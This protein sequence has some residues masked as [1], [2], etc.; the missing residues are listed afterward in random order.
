[1][2]RGMVF[3]DTDVH[4]TPFFNLTQPAMARH[5]AMF[6]CRTLDGARRKAAAYGFRGA[7]YPWETGISGDEECEKWLKL[8]THQSHITSDV[9]LAIQRYADCTGDTG[10]FEDFAAEVLI[11][12]AR[13]WVSKAVSNP[14]GSCSIPDAGGPDEFHV[15]CNDSAYVCNLAA[16]NLRLAAAAMH[17]LQATAPAK[18][19]ALVKRCGVA[20]D[21]EARFLDLAGRLRTMRRADGLFEQCAGFF[22]LGEPV[23]GAHGGERPFETQC[24]KQADV[25]MMMYLLPDQWSR[26]DLR[27][28][29]A[30]YEP[31]TIHASSLSHAVHGIVAARLGLS[32]V[33]D[34]YIRRSLGMDLNDEMGNADAGAHMAANGMN[35]LSIVEGYGGCRPC[36]DAFVIESPQL[37]KDWTRLI[38]RLKWRGADFEVEITHQA[39]AV[40][41]A[42]QAKPLPLRLGGKPMTLEP[43]GSTRL[44]CSP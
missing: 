40:R 20:G 27:A 28:N 1:M 12:T 4:M 37:P 13:F 24:V 5:L 36:G 6:R 44:A 14:D 9:A 10:F 16:N 3:W 32:D 2:Y 38:F 35:W 25:I 41:N 42:V 30:Y 34:R 17:R 22:G 7:S 11:E 23:A 18:L 43:G 21:E 26:E 31:R 19:A 33:A 29:Y 8:I 39:V 15:V